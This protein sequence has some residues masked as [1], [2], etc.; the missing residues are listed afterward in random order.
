MAI[1]SVPVFT[2]TFSHVRVKIQ[3]RTR[4]DLILSS[5]KGAR[6]FE[7]YRFALKA[8]IASAVALPRTHGKPCVDDLQA[9]SGITF[10]NRNG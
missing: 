9:P 2:T 3:R 5:L 8:Y 7:L 10:V 6:M 4:R 1:A